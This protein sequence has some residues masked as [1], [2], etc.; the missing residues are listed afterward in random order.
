MTKNFI[1]NIE[2]NKILKNTL[3]FNNPGL[4]GIVVLLIRIINNVYLYNKSKKKNKNELIIKNIKDIMFGIVF[5]FILNY[6]CSTNLCWA[7]WIL[8]SGQIIYTIIT[9][10]FLFSMINMLM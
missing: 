1:N 4:L 3:T 5:I 6:F 8:V 9:V 7:S 2:T 10:L